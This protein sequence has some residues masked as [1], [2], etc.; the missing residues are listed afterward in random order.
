[1]DLDLSII[2]SILRTDNGYFFAKKNG[3]TDA[4]LRGGSVRGWEFIDDHVLE[5]GEIPSISFFT[6][7]TGIDVVEPEDGL[8]VLIDDL[9]KR[10]LWTR[11]AASHEEIGDHL[12]RREVHEALEVFQSTSHEAFKDGLSGSGIGS[13]LASGSEV[14][15]FYEKMKRGERGII[16]PWEAMNEMTLGW[17]P[18]D[19]VVF[20]ARMGVGKTFLMLML[21]RQA[22]LEGKKVLFV[23]TEMPRSKLA[24]R[25]YAIHLKLPYQDLRKG[26]L[27]SPQ[28]AALREGIKDLESSE[29]LDVVGDDFDASIAEIE[30]AV[31]E[32]KPDILFVDGLYLVQNEGKDRHTRVSNTA[33]D[34]KKLARRKGIPVVTS[35]QFNREVGDNSKS[36]VSAANV[37]ISDVI[38]WN[39]DVMFGL[40]QTDDMEEDSIMGVRPMKI[41]EGK[42]KD[43]F[44]NWKFGEMN[45]DQVETDGSTPGNYGDDYDGIPDGNADKDWGDDDDDE[46]TLF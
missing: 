5:Y 27:A 12:G 40:F 35:T 42:G 44:S 26:Q 43:F 36:K 18:G 33:D 4:L 23:G 24:L 16:T 30:A 29:G 1:M 14:I 15:A 11:L 9:K 46:G 37:G 19:F 38:G 3:V 13:L 39:A 21:A 28:E 41:R 22:W 25:F 6:A 20:V 32:V 2:S 17:W 8:P 10:E 31:E 45:F 34:L 7:K